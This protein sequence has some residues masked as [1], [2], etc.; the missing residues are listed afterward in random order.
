MAEIATLL[1]V[2]TPMMNALITLASVANGI[3]YSRQ[4]LTLEQMGLANVPAEHLAAILQN[5]F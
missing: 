5:G 2:K 4:G 3:D 1:G